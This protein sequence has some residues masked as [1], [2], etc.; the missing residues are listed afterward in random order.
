MIAFW[1]GR[2]AFAFI[3]ILLAILPAVAV[4]VIGGEIFLPADVASDTDRMMGWVV[5]LWLGI[6]AGGVYLLA[7]FGLNDT[8][9]TLLDPQTGQTV[10]LRRSDTLYG[11]QV[12]YYPLICALGAAAALVWAVVEMWV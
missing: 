10:V 3:I 11:I 4:G 6:S 1:T 8:P 5:F 7:R 9:R 12:K 2:G